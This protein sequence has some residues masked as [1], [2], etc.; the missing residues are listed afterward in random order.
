MRNSTI[1]LLA[2]SSLW[3]GALATGCGGK[4][5]PAKYQIGGTVSGLQGSGLVLANGAEELP[6]SANGPFAF[7]TTVESG[8]GYSVTVRTQP[9]SPYQLCTVTGG[10]GSVAGA[11]VSSI[12][13]S[14]PTPGCQTVGSVA[15]DIFTRYL[16]VGGTDLFFELGKD[17]GTFKVVDISNPAAPVEKGSL[18][19]DKTTG[20]WF[21]GGVRLA[22]GGNFA[23]LFGGG[24]QGLPVIDVT[25]RAHPQAGSVVAGPS[26]GTMDLKICGSMAYAAVQGKGVAAFDVSSP[27]APV[28]KDELVVSGT[29]YPYA[30]TCRTRDATFDEVYLGDGGTG[31]APAGLRVFEYDK[32]THKFAAKGSYTPANDSWGGRGWAMSDSLLYLGWSDRSQLAVFDVSNKD[33]IPAPSVIPSGPSSNSELLVI[34]QTLIT[35]SGIGLGFFNLSSPTQPSL[36]GSQPLANS[37]VGLATFSHGAD[38]YLAYT[39]NGEATVSL[40]RLKLP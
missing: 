23:Y 4:P 38:R 25:D 9:T 31:T 19:L 35:G 21:A 3:L 22:P 17:Y 2:L 5:A 28:F 1:G 7:P 33:S 20:C 30:V 11:D 37:P 13:V 16:D 24:C 29:P 10:S 18:A 8:T 34:D 12:V 40:C 36:V 39:V 32:S 26:A 6:I 14:C 27:G 15:S